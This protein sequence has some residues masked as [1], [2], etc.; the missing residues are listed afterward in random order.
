M[1]ITRLATAW[2]KPISCGAQIIVMPSSARSIMVS[3]TSLIISG[4]SAL[5]GSSN[6]MVLGVMHSD[7]AMA[8]A[9]KEDGTIPAKGNA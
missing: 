7:R 5:V 4:S 1:K 9:V 3:R 8:A 6:S 2:A